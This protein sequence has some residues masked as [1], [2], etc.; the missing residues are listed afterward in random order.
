MNVRLL[1]PAVGGRETE[2]RAVVSELEGGGPLFTIFNVLLDYPAA[3]EAV[4]AEL[5][6]QRQDV[7][8]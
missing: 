8:G 3:L 6:R 1:R 7:G 2:T 5:L 4:R